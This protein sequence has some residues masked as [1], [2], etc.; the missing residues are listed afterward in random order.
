MSPTLPKR[1]NKGPK[2]YAQKAVVPRGSGFDTRLQHERHLQ[3]STKT[4]QCYR[5]GWRLMWRAAASEMRKHKIPARNSFDPRNVHKGEMPGWRKECNWTDNK[6]KRVLYACYKSG[7]LTF[8][9]LRDVRKA[10]SYLFELKT[11]GDVNRQQNWSGV[12][13]VWKTWF[14]TNRRVQPPVDYPEPTRP[15]N[16]VHHT[17][18][19]KNEDE[20]HGLVRCTNCSVGLGCVRSEISRRSRPN[21]ESSTTCPEHT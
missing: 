8:S 13:Q 15:Q 20:V 11:G 6:A 16:G 2:S 5:Y 10:L 7:Q 14:S 9:Q 19:T 12:K 17:M 21:Q 1:S 18:D 3:R 4:L